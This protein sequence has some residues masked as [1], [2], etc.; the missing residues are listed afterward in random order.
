MP[1][2]LIRSTHF[3]LILFIPPGQQNPIC[4]IPRLE[5]QLQE[6]YSLV[7]DIINP[8]YNV[9]IISCYEGDIH[10]P[11]SFPVHSGGETIRGCNVNV[12]VAVDHDTDTRPV[13]LI[14]ASQQHVNWQLNIMSPDVEIEQVELVST[15]V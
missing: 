13:I 11:N 9:H 14:L 12:D 7:P 10:G 8:K 15:S 1:H 4:A 6:T 5:N 2:S 3:T